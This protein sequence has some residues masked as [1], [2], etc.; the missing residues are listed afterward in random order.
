[1]AV[2]GGDNRLFPNCEPAIHPTFHLRPGESV[3]TIGSCFARNIERKLQQKGFHVPSLEFDAPVEEGFPGPISNILNKY[4][5]QGMLNEIL[6]ARF[7][8][9]FREPEAFLVEG[10]QGQVS[11]YQLHIAKPVSLDRA[12]ERREQVRSLFKKSIENSRVVVLTLGLIEVWKDSKSDVYLN[13]HPSYNM[14]T[15]H[16]GRFRFEILDYFS[17]LKVIKDIIVNLNQM[18]GDDIKI[19]LTVSPVPLQRTFTEEDVII[20]NCHSK[21]LL[22]CAAGEA[23]RCFDF[24]DYVPSYESVV[25]SDNHLTWIDDQVHVADGRIVR[26]IDRIVDA[27]VSEDVF[28]QS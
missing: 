7:G 12:L 10:A 14:V 8:S 2:K 20:A 21:S 4:S 23:A 18:R 15:L 27:Y 11:D 22:R 3:F 25:Y 16:D 24:V 9:K 13:E 26:V 17:T 19:M 1:M 28:A 5:P 6:Y